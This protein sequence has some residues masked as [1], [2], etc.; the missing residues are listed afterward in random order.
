MQRHLNKTLFALGLIATTLGSC[1]KY[2]DLS[3]PINQVASTAAFGTDLSA[4]AALNSIYFA[5][6]TQ[7]N[8]DGS[9][10]IGWQSGLYTDEL[11]NWSPNTTFL[12]LY[13]DKVSSTVGGVTATWSG[14]YKQLYSVN[15]ALETLPSATGLQY[16][17]QWLGEAYFLRGLM[18]F[19]LTN[20][21]GDVPLVLGTDYLKNNSL[22]RSPQTDVY[23]QIVADLLKAQSYLDNSYRTGNG[24]TTTSDRGRPNRMAATALLA[25]VYLY[26]G[27]WVNAEAQASTVIADNTD[28][29]LVAPAATFGLTSKEVIWGI[30]PGSST[31]YAFEVKDAPYYL[32]PNGKTPLAAGTFVS[33]SDSLVKS[34]EP[35]DARF[36]AW[37]GVD[38]VPAAGSTP[39]AVYYYSKKYKAVGVLTAPLEIIALFRLGEQYLIRA[40]ARARQN[41]INGA[42]S[43][44]NAIRTRANLP[45]A[46]SPDQATTLAAIAHERRVELFLEQGHRFLDLRRTGALDPLMTVVAPAKGGVWTSYNKWWPIP[47]ADVQ[48]DKNLIQTPGYN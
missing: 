43:D 13:Q 38:S 39:A 18:Y 22:A 35:N 17:N 45:A 16:Q 46:T 12:A 2:L 10:G 25:R 4:G 26:T 40:E 24:T 28:F 47:V 8:F 42:L 19:Y 1:K 29:Q 3:V 30:E 23:K 15:Q 31:L 6:Y 41:N 34:F 33:M 27:D 36:T 37:V 32:I 5:L 9:S 21:Y 14:L 11:I 44:L 7:G 48:N 20:F